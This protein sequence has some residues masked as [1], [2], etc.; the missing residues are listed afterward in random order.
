VGELIADQAEGP[1]EPRQA[2]R[3]GWVARIGLTLLNILACGTGLIRIGRVRLG[4]WLYA[5][6]LALSSIAFLLF[7]VSRFGLAAYFVAIAA[8]I[9]H[10]ALLIASIVLTLRLSGVRG[11]ATGLSS[12]P[13][14]GAMIILSLAV[15]YLAPSRF[16]TYSIPSENMDPL[17]KPGDY[18]VADLKFTEPERGQVIF[19]R[20]DEDHQ[21]VKR[22]V[23][24]PGDRVALRSGVVILNGQPVPQTEHGDYDQVDVFGQ[25]RVVRA[26]LEQFPGEAAPH[27][28]LDRGA[29]P[30][31]EFSEAVVPAGHIFVLGD[32]RDHSMDSRFPR[33]FGPGG[34][35]MLPVSD[36]LGVLQF[37]TWSG[38]PD[39]RFKSIAEVQ[40]QTARPALKRNGE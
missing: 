7:L 25:R 26:K 14:I 21:W 24:L 30:Q 18:V 27:V 40:A 1:V 2:E 10:I 35:G 16:K 9:T 6:Q 17:L 39:R 38:D 13:A 11:A 8:A 22:V 32:N 5:S 20:M 34:V 31:D 28:V 15:A 36:V 37:F 12:W 4:L 33:E 29:E 19:F 23:G 3:R